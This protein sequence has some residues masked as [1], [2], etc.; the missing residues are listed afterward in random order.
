M[1][2]QSFNIKFMYF[3]INFVFMKFLYFDFFLINGSNEIF[4]L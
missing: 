1:D 2:Q 4:T 3:E